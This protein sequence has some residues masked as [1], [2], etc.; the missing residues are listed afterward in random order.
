M[1]MLIIL[2]HTYADK[3]IVLF[4]AVYNVTRRNMQSMLG[5]LSVEV[6]AN[7]SSVIY[8]KFQSTPVMPELFGL[9]VSGDRL[10]LDELDIKLW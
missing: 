7:C 5:S 10:L 6:H 3:T 4:T 2:E 1:E 8:I 9:F